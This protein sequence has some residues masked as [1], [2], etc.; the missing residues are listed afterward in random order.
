MLI[1]LTI[2]LKLPSIFKI[3]K[4]IFPYRTLLQKMSGND[5]FEGFIPDMMKEMTKILGVEF[6]INVVKDGRLSQFKFS[7]IKNKF[8]NS[9][10]NDI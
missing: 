9:N 8:Y 5:K 10:I 3:L 4:T 6:S 7:V 2:I 1:F